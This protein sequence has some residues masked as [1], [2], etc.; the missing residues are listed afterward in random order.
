MHVCLMIANIVANLHRLRLSC[1]DVQSF[2]SLTGEQFHNAFWEWRS[3]SD[4]E[5]V[6]DVQS[7]LST[8]NGQEFR[9]SWLHS[10]S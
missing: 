5:Q 2:I 6:P 8:I 10:C 7:Q 4:N 1:L 3:H 9:R